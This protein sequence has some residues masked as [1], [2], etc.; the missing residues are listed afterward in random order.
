MPPAAVPARRDAPPLGAGARATISRVRDTVHAVLAARTPPYVLAVSG[1][2]DSMVLLDAAHSVLGRDRASE[3]RIVV[4]TFDHGT[5]PTATAAAALVARQARSL[6]IPCIVGRTARPGHTEAE[7]RQARWRFLREALEEQGTQ[8]EAAPSGREHR[9]TIVTAHTRDDQVETVFMRILR[10][11]GPRGL[12]ALYAESAVCRPLLEISRSEITAYA[13]ERQLPFV[14]D[15]SNTDRRH[16]RNR[17]RH[18][19]LPAIGAVHPRFADE[20]LTLAHR[21]AAWRRRMDRLA[22]TF[23]VM[24]DTPGSYVIP[25]AQF[26]GY[27][28]DALRALWPSVA[29][30]AGV[31]MDRRGT[32]RLASFTIEGETGQ[33]IQLS[34]GVD[35]LMRRDAMVF[36]R[37]PRE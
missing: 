8:G 25:R 28:V 33:S 4:A 12:A 19:L 3:P 15:P 7:W 31:V 18:D 36:H 2:V 32:H 22:A 21:A 13:R 35:V 37:R 16:L 9:G 17:I 10:D 5:G 6:G 30:R 29:A 11:A 34:G 27:G 26:A 20:L 14:T 1:G 23:T 24:S